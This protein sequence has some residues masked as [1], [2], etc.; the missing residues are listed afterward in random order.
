MRGGLLRLVLSDLRKDQTYA[1][2]HAFK[3]V[4]LFRVDLP[5]AA[6][7]PFLGALPLNF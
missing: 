2:H 6:L 5:K 4:N 3:A 1:L 7:R